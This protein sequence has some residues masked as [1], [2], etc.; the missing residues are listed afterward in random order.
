MGKAKY[1]LGPIGQGSKMKLAVNMVM[2]TMM[3]ALGEGMAVSYL[4][5]NINLYHSSFHYFLR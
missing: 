1:F 4:L 5:F 3:T 2:G